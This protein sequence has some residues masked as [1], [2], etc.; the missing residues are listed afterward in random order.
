MQ[1]KARAKDCDA[2][3]V[4]YVEYVEYVRSHFL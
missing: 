4:E 3:Y 1:D 2:A